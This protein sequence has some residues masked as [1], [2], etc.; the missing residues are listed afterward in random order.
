[1]EQSNATQTEEATSSNLPFVDHFRK[2]RQNP[3]W[4]V[5]LIVFVVL[6]IILVALTSYI[7]DNT[8][9]FKDMGMSQSEIDKQNQFNWAS[10]IGQSIGAII[11]GLLIAFVIFLVISKIMKSDAQAIH[12][13]SASISYLIITTSFSII[14]YAIQALFGLTIPETQLDSLN[15]FDKGNNY[16]AA[17]SLSNLLAAYVIFAV[18]YGTS[19]L[20]KKASIIWAVVALIVMVGFTL[21]GAA[22]SESMKGL[23]NMQ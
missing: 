2:I 8:K 10:T 9:I 16:L 18:Y 6:S 21:G 12:I 7:T 4:I 23:A 13:F 15:I 22:I 1:M 17:F 5:K 11:M 14:V 19:R 20:S 3:K